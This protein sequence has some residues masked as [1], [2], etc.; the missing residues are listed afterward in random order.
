VVFDIVASATKEKK[1]EA[2]VIAMYQS[3]GVLTFARTS[4]AFL[5]AYAEVQSD[6]LMTVPAKSGPNRYGKID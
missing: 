3:T 5:F 2:L 4:M 1:M 6:Y